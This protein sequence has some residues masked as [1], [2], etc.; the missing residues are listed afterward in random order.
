M[1][2]SHN[3][4]NVAKLLEKAAA[5]WQ[6]S[7][8]DLVLVTDNASNMVVAAQKANF[9]PPEMLCSHCQLGL[10]ESSQAGSCGKAPGED[11]VD[12]Y[13]FPPQY[14]RTPP[15]RGEP[16][17]AWSQTAQTEDGRNG[18][19]PK[20]DE[21]RHHSDVSGENPTVRLIAPVHT[22]LLQNTEPNTKDSPLVR[23]IKKAVHDDLS[24]RYTSEAE[25]S[26][27]YTAS[28]L[29]LRFK[30]LPFLTEEEREQTYGKV[31][32]EAASLE[33][34]VRVEEETPEDNGRAAAAVTS[35][36]EEHQEKELPPPAKRSCTL[37]E[38]LFGPAFTNQAPEPKSAYTRAEDE[39]AKYRLALTPRPANLYAFCIQVLQPLPWQMREMKTGRDRAADLP[40]RRGSM[41]PRSF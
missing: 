38:N 5:E 9:L 7:E 8:K 37:L 25:K 24:S 33:Q 19:R 32:A 30:T 13:I 22:K 21:R 11:Q 27:L 34:E 3:G 6:I 23:D 35:D 14:H 16:K 28:A 31:I 20:A 29:D 40:K 41:S 39:M 26:L 18:L 1:S 2:E 17:A 15:A 4:A 10:T 36:T 12:L